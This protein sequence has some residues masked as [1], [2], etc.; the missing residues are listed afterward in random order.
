MRVHK[1]LAK[2]NK[3]QKFILICSKFYRNK[4]KA[5]YKKNYALWKWTYII[6]VRKIIL[7]TKNTYE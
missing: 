5:G 1:D 7:S 2:R 6:L 3:Q 4:Q